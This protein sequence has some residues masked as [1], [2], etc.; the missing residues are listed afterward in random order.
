MRCHRS[1]RPPDTISL[2]PANRPTPWYRWSPPRRSRSPSIVN[3][4]PAGDSVTF[5]I[6]GITYQSAR[7]LASGLARGRRLAHHLRR[8]WINRPAPVS[9][10]TRVATSSD[11]PPR[12]GCFTSLS[13]QGR[14][15]NSFDC[16]HVA[17]PASLMLRLRWPPNVKTID[18]PLRM[19][20]YGEPANGNHRRPLHSVACAGCPV[21]FGS[22]AKLESTPSPRCVPAGMKA[23]H[24]ARRPDP[25]S[26]EG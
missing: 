1:G 10:L 7:R 9:D 6:D 3:A 13:E 16:R 20:A 5:A 19:K 4:E 21:R 23:C 18:V 8:W 17:F 11:Q 12:A 2:P 25:R 26:V 15:P 14:S 24:A 22:S